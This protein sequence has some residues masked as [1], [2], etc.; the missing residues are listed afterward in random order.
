[1][2]RR[3]KVGDFYEHCSYEPTLAIEVNYQA[4]EITGISLIDGKLKF[5]SLTGCGVRRL[6]AVEA[7]RSKIS[8]PHKTNSSAEKWI[9]V[10]IGERS[11][12]K[13][14]KDREKCWWIVNRNHSR[15]RKTLK[16]WFGIKI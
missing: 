13:W 4:D 16:E 2:A 7:I 1:V 11:W 12:K 10:C 14:L 3:L 15:K 8:G 5:C 9:K 6:T